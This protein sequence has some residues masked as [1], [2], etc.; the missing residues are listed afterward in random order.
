M[1][2]FFKKAEGSARSVEIYLGASLLCF[3]GSVVLSSYLM[4]FLLVHPA[5]VPSGRTGILFI[6]IFHDLGYLIC[7]VLGAAAISRIVDLSRWRLAL[8]LVVPNYFY[9]EMI[10]F[11]SGAEAVYWNWPWGFLGRIL[12]LALT[13]AASVLLQYRGGRLKSDV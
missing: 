3:G 8:A 1:S 13:V 5:L 4:S 6:T 11:I 7:S 2:G 9:E 12:L 10:R